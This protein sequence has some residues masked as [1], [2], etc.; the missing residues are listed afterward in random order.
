MFFCFSKICHKQQRLSIIETKKSL[1][2]TLVLH[3]TVIPS[4]FSHSFNRPRKSSQKTKIWAVT[5]GLGGMCHLCPDTVLAKTAHWGPDPATV[6]QNEQYNTSLA[7]SQCG[8]GLTRMLYRARQNTRNSSP[9]PPPL[10]IWINGWSPKEINLGKFL[11]LQQLEGPRRIVPALFLLLL[12]RKRRGV[13]PAHP[14][15]V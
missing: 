8:H 2:K 11:L 15:P 14:V 12:V 7:G 1:V 6:S 4:L 5:L 9:P 10:C 3:H 13:T